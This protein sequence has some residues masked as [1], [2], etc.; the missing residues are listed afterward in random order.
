MNIAVSSDLTGSEKITGM[1]F[2]PASLSTSIAG[3]DPHAVWLEGTSHT[4]A[5]LIARTSAGN[6]NITARFHDIRQSLA[7]LGDCRD[8]QSELGAGP[9]VNSK[10]IPRGDRLLASTGLM[11]RGFGFPYGPSLHIGATGWYLLAALGGNPLQLGYS[12][13]PRGR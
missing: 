5:A 11:D 10:S 2:D 8:A 12:S 9:T 3:C 7:F 6:E 4:V 1:V 13:S